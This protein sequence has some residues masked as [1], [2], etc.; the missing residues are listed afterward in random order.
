MK[1]C[2]LFS[3]LTLAGLT[4]LVGLSACGKSNGGSSS[5][6]SS[7]SVISAL[8]PVK[9]VQGRVAPLLN[10]S[11]SKKSKMVKRLI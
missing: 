10:F 2:K 1:K 7:A 11:E 3:V 8:F 5:A 4:A 9:M 6:S